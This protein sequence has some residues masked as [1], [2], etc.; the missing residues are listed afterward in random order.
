[1]ESTNCDCGNHM[2]YAKPPVS[3]QSLLSSHELSVSWAW[4][5]RTPSAVENLALSASSMLTSAVSSEGNA[6]RATPSTPTSTPRSS[7]TYTTAVT[8]TITNDV[9]C[10]PTAS[11][12]L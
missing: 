2:K 7:A 4:M 8:C 3:W 12:K 6:M 11:Q 10:K 5:D 1:M 9:P